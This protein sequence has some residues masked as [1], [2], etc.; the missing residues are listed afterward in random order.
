MLKNLKL[1]LLGKCNHNGKYILSARLA[2]RKYEAN[3]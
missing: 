2:E 1:V 3:Q